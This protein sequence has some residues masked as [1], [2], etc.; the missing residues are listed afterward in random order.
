MYHPWLCDP[1]QHHL[2]VLLELHQAVLQFADHDVQLRFSLRL[3]AGPLN[4]STW[5][6][7]VVRRPAL[8][9]AMQPFDSAR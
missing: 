9:Q 3:W 1:A 5:T 4:V 6:G 7:S 2:D 8:P